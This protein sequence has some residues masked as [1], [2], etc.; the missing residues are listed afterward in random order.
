MD[1][2]K[3]LIEGKK[4][5]E[6]PKVYKGIYFDEDIARFLDGVQ[7]GNK[8]EVVNKILRQYLNDNDLI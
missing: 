6:G 7:H 4:K 2:I 5:D 3:K 1:E 8:S